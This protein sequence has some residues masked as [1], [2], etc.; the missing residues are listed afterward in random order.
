METRRRGGQAA[1]HTICR[2]PTPRAG[3]SS[4]GENGEYPPPSLL[5]TSMNI[6]KD[7]AVSLRFK[8]ADLQ[9]KLIED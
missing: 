1:Q 3:F 6:A 5:N 4:L 9:G 8:V 7:T 2:R